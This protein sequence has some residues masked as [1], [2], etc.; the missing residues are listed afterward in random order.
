MF[1]A[2]ASLRDCLS[3]CLQ[4]SDCKYNFII[5]RGLPPAEQCNQVAIYWGNSIRSRAD[6]TDCCTEYYQTDIKITLTRCCIQADAG[7]SF[8]AEAEERETECF[9]NDV[10]SIRDCLKCI[11]GCALHDY[12]I[13]CGAIV[14]SISPDFQTEGGCYSATFTLQVTEG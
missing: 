6:N 12:I 4:T 11:Q 10:C 3:S 5:S 7:K 9:L 1:A 8:N 14:T 13:G 2:L